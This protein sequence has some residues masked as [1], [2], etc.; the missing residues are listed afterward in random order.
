VSRRCV[1]E[2]VAWPR[3]DGWPT[4][5]L[6]W[7]ACATKLLG[8]GVRDLR[9]RHKVRRHLREIVALPGFDGEVRRGR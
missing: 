8:S 4:D 9:I 1:R 2:G 3:D 6:W 7:R 5:P